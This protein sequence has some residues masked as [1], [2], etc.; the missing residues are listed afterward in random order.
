MKR[1]LVLGLVV[2]VAVGFG[3]VE[4]RIRAGKEGPSQLA[5]ERFADNWSRHRDHIRL[6]PA[7]CEGQD[8]LGRTRTVR[9]GPGEQVLQRKALPLESGRQREDDDRSQQR[10]HSST[11]NRFRQGSTAST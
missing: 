11:E 5:R 7:G 9:T 3:G 1:K 2:V 8:D 4:H 6:Q 10:C